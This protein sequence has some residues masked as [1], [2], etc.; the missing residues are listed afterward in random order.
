[1]TKK[2][3]E[4]K[5]SLD[6]IEPEIWRKFVVESSITLDDL[7]EIIQVVMGWENAHLYGFHINGVEYQPADDDFEN[8]AED[9]KGMKLSQLKLEKITKIRYIYDFG[10]SWEHTIKINKI[11]KPEEELLT[12]TC[13]DGARNCPP[14]DCGSVPGYEDIVEA[15]KKPTSKRAKEFIEWLGEKYDPEEFDLKKINKRLQPKKP[16]RK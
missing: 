5:I 10:D 6:G 11:Y 12:P 13:I 4:M 15:M 2:I 1:M 14:E 9:T 16:K 8:D 7:H 3:I